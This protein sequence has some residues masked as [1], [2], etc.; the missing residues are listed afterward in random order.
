MI[1]WTDELTKPSAVGLLATLRRQDPGLP[2]WQAADRCFADPAA[3]TVKDRILRALLTAYRRQDL[4]A[5]PL[6]I[7]LLWRRICARCNGDEDQVQT[8]VVAVL[9]MAP[10]ADHGRAELAMRLVSAACDRIRLRHPLMRTVPLS[11]LIPP[12]APP[13]EPSMDEHHL[14]AAEA[15]KLLKL[16][17]RRTLTSWA[18][19]G[20]ITPVRLPNGH[21]RYT[22][23]EIDRVLAGRKL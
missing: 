12:A 4:R 20:R 21:Y 17:D 18:K 8:L 2:E 19:A 7:A 14:T 11:D 9:E 6:I 15:A 5:G 23:G 1:T 16:K 3:Q 10:F 13:S 22:Q